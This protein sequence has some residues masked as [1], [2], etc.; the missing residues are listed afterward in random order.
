MNTVL[1][2][3][4]ACSAATTLFYGGQMHSALNALPQEISHVSMPYATD[5]ERISLQLTRARLYVDM[6]ILDGEG[7]REALRH[8]NVA[9]RQIGRSELPGPLAALYLERGRLALIQQA[10]FQRS[11]YSGA[12]AALIHALEHARRA[13]D[14]A[15]QAAVRVAWSGMTFKLGQP[16]EA[17]DTA[18]LA[19]DL[20]QRCGRADIEADALH[21]LGLL[22]RAWGDSSA[23]LSHL[24]CALTLRMDD[25]L[26]V[27]MA[28]TYVAL[29]ETLM[30]AGHIGEA[31][32]HLTTA[33]DL[34]ERYGTRRI[35]AQ[36]ALTLAELFMR[37]ERHS[38]GWAAARTGRNLACQVR[39]EPLIA[40]AD[41]LLTQL[42]TGGLSR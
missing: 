9:E 36:A 16:E 28:A 32:T 17:L 27:W 11:D 35:G 4:A 39:D 34:A 14:M 19:L 6:V 20:A 13:G 31:H 7:T 23:A 1:D 33:A 38:A 25:G 29:G 12:R 3:H 37:T 18:Q 15:V 5:H 2:M 41:R 26:R 24:N 21:T 40:R 22:L 30:L 10:R 8:L 42:G